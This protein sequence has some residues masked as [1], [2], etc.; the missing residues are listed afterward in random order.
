VGL[1]GVLFAQAA[2]HIAM[3]LGLIPVIGVGLPFVSYGGSSILALFWGFG[4]MQSMR[5]HG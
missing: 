1:M 4:M 3:N 5:L 2:V